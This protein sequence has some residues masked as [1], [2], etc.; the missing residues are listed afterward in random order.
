[1]KL[2]H[3]QGANLS[4]TNQGNDSIF[5]ETNNY[6]QRADSCFEFHKTLRKNGKNFQILDVAGNKAELIRLVN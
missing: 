4:I 3:Q 6:L 5:G 1:M 2:Y